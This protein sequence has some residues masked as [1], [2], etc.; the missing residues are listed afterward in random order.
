M[1]RHKEAQQLTLYGREASE[2][3]PVDFASCN[4]GSTGVQA[5]MVACLES[6][7]LAH[8]NHIIR[9]V[10][11]LVLEASENDKD[12]EFPGKMKFLHFCTRMQWKLLIG[13]ICLLLLIAHVLR[14]LGLGRHPRLYR[15]HGA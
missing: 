7:S 3:S 8:L 12:R 5:Q 15:C 4:F 11:S 1:D 6:L 13:Q 2:R 10:A 14:L 9:M